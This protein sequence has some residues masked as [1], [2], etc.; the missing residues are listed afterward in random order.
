M[1]EISQETIANFLQ[2]GSQYM[3]PAAALLR[4]LYS[5]IRGKIPEGLGEI[6]LASLFAGL[7][8][9]LDS[10]QLDFRAIVLEILGNTVFMAGLLTFIMIY[11]LRQPDRGQWVDGIVGGV[12]G[13][14]AWAG[15][16]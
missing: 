9:V 4:A 11:L 15:W 2:L 6:F 8:A 3:L 5:G 14:I 7:T 13:L 10:Q 12:I 1:I 16:V